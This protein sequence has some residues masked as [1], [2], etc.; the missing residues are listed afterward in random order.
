MKIESP[1]FFVIILLSYVLSSP[2]WNDN[3]FSIKRIYT[4][5]ATNV[6]QL[7]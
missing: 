6:Y 3:N 2:A 1:P 5:R 4:F 7:I